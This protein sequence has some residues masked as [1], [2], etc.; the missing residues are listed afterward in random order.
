MEGVRW[1]PL[2]PGAAARHA[3]V[4][5]DGESASANS[6][7]SIHLGRTLGAGATLRGWRKRDS[8][9]GGMGGGGL[10]AGSSRRR[11]RGVGSEWEGI[12]SRCTA[13]GQE[14]MDGLYMHN[15]A[16]DERGRCAEFVVTQ[17]GAGIHDKAEDD[18]KLAFVSGAN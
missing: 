6:S 1:W 12:C 14:S 5:L 16:A 8:K 10:W 2:C 11:A 7:P 9:R 15:C 17:S 3:L 4:V 13:E 18:H